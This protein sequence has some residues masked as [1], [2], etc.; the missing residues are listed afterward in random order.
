M[1]KQEN[2][3]ANLYGLLVQ[4]QKGKIIDFFMLKFLYKKVCV[5]MHYTHTCRA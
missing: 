3:A 5:W 1:L 2:L 4:K